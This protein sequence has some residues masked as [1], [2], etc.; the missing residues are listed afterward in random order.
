MVLGESIPSLVC[1]LPEAEANQANK[2]SGQRNNALAATASRGTGH[3]RGKEFL[4]RV[5]A[6]KKKAVAAMMAP[7]STNQCFSRK[8]EGG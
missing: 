6:R 3:S 7:G 2:D 8:R 4:G 5:G 1:Q